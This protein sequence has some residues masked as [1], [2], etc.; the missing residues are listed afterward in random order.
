MGRLDG[1]VAIVTGAS[2]GIGLGIAQAYAREG[3]KVVLAARRADMLKDAADALGNGAMPVTTDVSKEDDVINL[4]A[5]T[6]KA[7][8]RVD[9][10]VVNAGTNSNFATVDMPLDEWRRVIDNNLTG[11]FLCMRE[12]FRHMQGQGSG[13][14]ITMGSITAKV[15]R[16]G[17]M[18]YAASKW[19]LEGMTRQMAI[20]GREHNIAV[21]V[22]QP[23]N[24]WSELKIGR[25]EQ[26]HREGIM[27]A[28]EVASVAVAMAALPDGVNMLEA[29]IMPITQPLVGRG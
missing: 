11:A 20:D 6:R 4:F 9:V 23:G 27:T 1:K 13:R 29:I 3:A 16:A 12:A 5:E 7:F 26:Q 8:G 10:A 21:S 24:T 15:P 14:I 18:V 17:R 25:E 22:I 2:S 28:A 19:A